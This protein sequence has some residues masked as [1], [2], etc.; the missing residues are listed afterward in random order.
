MEILK[1]FIKWLECKTGSKFKEIISERI[2]SEKTNLANLKSTDKELFYHREYS[3]P[4]ILFEGFPL[5]VK[6]NDIKRVNLDKRKSFISRQNFKL[7]K[8][9]QNFGVSQHYPP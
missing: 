7:I 2:S 9:G 4:T 5:E 8:Q 1:A 3:C 6:I